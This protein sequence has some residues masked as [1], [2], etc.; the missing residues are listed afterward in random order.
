MS[1]SIT[2]ADASYKDFFEGLNCQI[3]KGC[4]AVILTSNQEENALLCR[5]LTGMA[6]L[7]TGTVSIDNRPVNDLPPDE[8]LRIRQKTGYIPSSGGLI[9]NLKM[10]ENIM[11]PTLYHHGTILDDQESYAEQLLDFFG[12]SKNIMALPATLSLYEKRITAFVRSA[13][14]KP[15]IMLYSG[16]FDGMSEAGCDK[17]SKAAYMLHASNPELT[18]LLLTSSEEIPEYF[19]DAPLYYL[20]NEQRNNVRNS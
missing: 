8:L 15:S 6:S 12:F 16:C 3:P 11:L 4:A 14:Q 18:S 1:Y 17:L 5:L 7:T 9:S 19:S 13:I 2:F 10:W 20:H